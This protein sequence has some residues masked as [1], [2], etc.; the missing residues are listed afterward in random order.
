MTHPAQQGQSDG[1]RGTVLEVS[2]SVSGPDLRVYKVLV[3][4]VQDPVGGL[5]PLRVRVAGAGGLVRGGGR[6]VRLAVTEKPRP[7]LTGRL[8]SL[9]LRPS[10][11]QLQLEL[12]NLL[13]TLLI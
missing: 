3:V 2:E 4:A 1:L 10:L 12:L 13:V 9:Q 8:L 5:V 6:V 11:T 7:A